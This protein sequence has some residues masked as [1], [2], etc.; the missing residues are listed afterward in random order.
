[1]LEELSQLIEAHGIRGPALL[2]IGEV[3]GL[4]T[5]P[6]ATIVSTAQ[7]APAEEVI[8]V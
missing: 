5:G 7:P 8:S 4:R 1:M 2:I 3:A 6:A